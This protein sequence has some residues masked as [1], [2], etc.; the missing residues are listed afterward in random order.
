[1]RRLLTFVSSLYILTVST[2]VK[3]DIFLWTGN[4]VI[5]GEID[6]PVTAV[7]SPVFTSLG[8]GNG[9]S[10]VA[11][12]IRTFANDGT[13]AFDTQFNTP[14]SLLSYTITSGA[15]PSEPVL[16]FLTTPRK[17]SPGRL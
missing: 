7:I 1:M 6:G 9:Y 8:Y 3:A 15:I 13:V 16:L 12:G 11:Y 17:P 5:E 14:P 2:P 10:V 4:A